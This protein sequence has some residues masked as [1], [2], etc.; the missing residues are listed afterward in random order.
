LRKVSRLE[1]ASGCVVERPDER[2][3]AF[4]RNEFAY[5]DA[6]QSADPNRIDPLDVL[7][8]VAM[9]SRVDTAKKVRQV[10]EGL[11]SRC[12]PILPS[13]PEDADLLDFEE[14]RR[15]LRDLLDAA[16]QTPGVLVATATKVLHRKRRFL[17]SMLDSVV[18]RHYLAAKPA[19]LR[20]CVESDYK[21]KPAA[22]G[23]GTSPWGR[24]RSRT[25]EVTDS[26]AR[27]TVGLPRL[28]DL[29]ESG[30]SERDLSS[31]PISV[32]RPF[33]FFCT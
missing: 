3:L 1:L 19:S 17:I 4:C 27:R 12:D 29:G 16:V 14:W 13:I 30:S 26:S 25:E 23:L 6:F 7:A 9:N 2:M 5:Y 15:P 11:A 33:T 28:L 31:T 8:T 10:H 32:S 21:S 18:L 24:G 20:V 22:R